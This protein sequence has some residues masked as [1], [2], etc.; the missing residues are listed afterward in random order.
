MKCGRRPPTTSSSCTRRE[1]FNAR[2]PNARAASV[3][4]SASPVRSS[5]TNGSTAPAR[6]IAT[7]CALV[8]C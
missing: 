5:C 3:R 1:P 8:I 7:R 6:T 4:P 2:L